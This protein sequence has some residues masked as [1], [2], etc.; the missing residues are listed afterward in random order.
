MN[1]ISVVDLYTLT[2]DDLLEIGVR[3]FGVRKRL[4]TGFAID[5]AS[6]IDKLK[7]SNIGPE[8]LLTKE[9]LQTRKEQE[10]THYSMRHSAYQNISIVST[11]IAGSAIAVAIRLEPSSEEDLAADVLYVTSSVLAVVAVGC[12][13]LSTTVF[14]LQGFFLSR[15]A[16]N[17]A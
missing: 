9:E 11:L 16:A 12:N 15:L 14:T 8:A 5:K 7:R 1:D 6:A 3:S 10:A 4:L 17:G 2:N 13:L